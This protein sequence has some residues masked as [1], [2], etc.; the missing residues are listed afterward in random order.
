[1]T[2]KSKKKKR[3]VDRTGRQFRFT[4]EV[5]NDPSKGKNSTVILSL[6]MIILASLLKLESLIKSFTKIF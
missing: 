3:P 4:L 6:S 2:G 5:F 1:M